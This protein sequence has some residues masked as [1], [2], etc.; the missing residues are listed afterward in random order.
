MKASRTA[1]ALLYR[2]IGGTDWPGHAAVINDIGAMALGNLFSL[3]DIHCA[4]GTCVAW[5]EHQRWKGGRVV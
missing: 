1:C 2:R 3:A 4:L 5:S